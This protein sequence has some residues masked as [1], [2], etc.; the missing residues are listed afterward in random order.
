MG[1]LLMSW[2]GV[3]AVVEPVRLLKSLQAMVVNQP[4]VHVANTR[5][6]SVCGRRHYSR[7]IGMDTAATIDHPQQIAYQR[8]MRPLTRNTVLVSGELTEHESC[9]VCCQSSRGVKH[10]RIVL[11]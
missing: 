8:A 6:T 2:D 3:F 4:R 9:G 7:P 11:L 5:E 10:S 1:L